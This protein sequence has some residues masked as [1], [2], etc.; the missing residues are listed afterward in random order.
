M[1]NDELRVRQLAYRIWESE[2]RP[3]GQQQRHWDM[4]L[5]IVAAEQAAGRETLLEDEGDVQD[6]PPILEEG[7]P[8]EDDERGIEEDRLPLEDPDGD[9]SL[10]EAPYRDDVTL[11]ETVPVQDRA[12]SSDEP[13]ESSHALDTENP[14]DEVE[15]RRV[16]EESRAAPK[17]AAPGKARKPAAKK[18]TARKA[19]AKKTTAKKE[20]AGK[21][22]SK[23]KSTTSTPR[24]PRG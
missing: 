21:T 7:L 19:A 13:L 20:T 23:K 17:K 3:E 24:K 15:I 14:E 18:D 6:E 2:G 9:P 12:G 22:T 5:K 16:P 11:E 4:A 10:D 8:L 1:A